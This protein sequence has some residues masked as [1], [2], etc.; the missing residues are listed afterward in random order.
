MPQLNEKSISQVI[1]EIKNGVQSPLKRT[2]DNVNL[3]G[4]PILAGRING[5]FES[6]EYVFLESTYVD[7]C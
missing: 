5:R 3:I 4:S 1:T 7:W 2:Q 6:K